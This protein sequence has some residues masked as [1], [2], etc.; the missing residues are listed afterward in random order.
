MI[1]TSHMTE[2]KKILVL[3][4]GNDCL[5]DDA[6]GLKVVR[7]LRRQKTIV[8]DADVLETGAA[9]MIL[10]DLMAGYRALILIDAIQTGDGKPGRIY[11]LTED[12]LP[13]ASGPSE[14]IPWS[15]H[16]MGLRGIL[17]T[18]RRAGGDLPDT[19]IVYAIETEISREWRRGCGQE[20]E[21][22]IPEVVRR[23]TGE[24]HSLAF[25]ALEEKGPR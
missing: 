18:G 5:G 20:V 16:H 3:G 17:E 9:G 12:D 4:L 13:A 6:V 24:L 21:R 23:V 19:V 7:E 14:V 10:L 22:A 8:K 1:S 15:V 11:R 2:A 25:S